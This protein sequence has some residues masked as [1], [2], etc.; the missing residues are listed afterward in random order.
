[1]LPK[2]HLSSHSRISGSSEWS[3]HHSYL[4][5]LYLFLYGSSVYFCHL[6]LIFSASIRS[7]PFLSFIE[8]IFAWN[9]PLVSLIFLRYL[10]S[11]LF[12]CF[13]IF[14][15]I[16]HWGRLP[17]LSLL[18]FGTLHSDGYI[19]PFLPCLLLFFY[20]QL[21]VRLPQ[22]TILPFCIS[23]P[24]GWSWFLSPVQCSEPLSIV[25]QAAFWKFSKWETGKNF[26]I[27]NMN[28][29]SFFFSG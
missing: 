21:F 24:C 19:F 8:P 26:R 5:H 1:M 27:R 2:A 17:Y 18:F 25:L 9:I 4:G 15:C 12:Y 22:T 23:F 20:S 16:D 28:F 3:H 14:I 10:W 29:G 6:F 13:P 11:F 7:I